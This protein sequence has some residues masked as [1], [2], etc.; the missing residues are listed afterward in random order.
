MARFAEREESRVPAPSEGR[1]GGCR[2]APG[3]WA[4][5][6]RHRTSEG[7]VA[8]WRCECGA[9]AITLDGVALH[10]AGKASGQESE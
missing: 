5:L 7:D 3:A 2:R 1:S 6:S 8:Y 4:L 9:M 10:G